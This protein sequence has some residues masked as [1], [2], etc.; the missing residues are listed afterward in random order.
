MYTVLHNSRCGKSRD[1][2]KVM[3]EAA[4]EYEVREY[5]KDELSFDELKDVIAQLNVSP[6]EIVR[7]NE[8]IWKEQFKGKDYSDDELITIMVENPKLIQRPIVLQN[9][10]GVIGRPVE[11]IVEFIK[12]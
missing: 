5:L 10:E 7:T 1:A 4:V 9:G 3:E 11:N 6:M 2:I 8:V 12:K